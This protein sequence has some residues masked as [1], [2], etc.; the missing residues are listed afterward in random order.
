MDKKEKLVFATNNEHK[1][2]EVREL[3]SS[4]YEVLGL[5][6]IGC[7][8]DIPETATTL[9]GNALLK[10]RYV[11]E[12]Y[13]L[14]CFS[15]DTGLE[16][17][18]LGNEPGVYS[19]RYAGEEKS[20]QANVEKL[21]RNLVKHDNRRARFRTSIAYIKDEKEIL[22]DGVVQGEISDV[23]RGDMGF[24]YDPIFIPEGYDKTFAELGDEVKNNISHRALA[25]QKLYVY[26]TK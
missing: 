11:W 1:L 6:D 12:N 25:V 2:K 5:A 4:K 13:Q 18:A 3:L 26:L 14:P 17:E 7:F 15:D 20:S 23:P 16:V 21:L 24:G 22:F 19:A 9:E 10:A 8:Y